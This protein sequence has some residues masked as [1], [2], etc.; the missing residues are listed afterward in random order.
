[1]NHKPVFY[2][3]IKISSWYQRF[4]NNIIQLA[5]AIKMAL[6]NHAYFKSPPHKYISTIEVNPQYNDGKILKKGLFFND[7]NDRRQ[8]IIQ[9]YVRP[10]LI[11]ILIKPPAEDE[12]LF[13]HL[14]SGDIFSEKPH[15]LYVQNP[16]C[17][18]LKVMS[19]FKR[20]IVISED[21][22]NPVT[23]ELAKQQNTIVHVNRPFEID[24]AE[25]LSAKNLCLSGVG[26]IGPVICAL[27]KNIRNIYHTNLCNLQ[28]DSIKLFQTNLENYLVPGQW[29]NSEQQRNLMMEYDCINSFCEEQNPQNTATFE[30]LA[31][32]KTS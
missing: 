23:K 22:K 6:D 26:T 21:D 18:F 29:V 4:G 30:K 8:R 14:R 24:L 9:D 2:M 27:S 5:N 1:M 13:V 19:N 25:L 11:N 12:I 16:L 10:N 7:Q 20:T 32:Q 28:L 3:E 31:G 15:P 17:Y